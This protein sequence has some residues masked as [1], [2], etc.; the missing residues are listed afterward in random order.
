VIDGILQF[1][2]ASAAKNKE[3]KRHLKNVTG[4][5]DSRFSKNKETR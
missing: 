1:K 3:D 4:C 5:K 2:H